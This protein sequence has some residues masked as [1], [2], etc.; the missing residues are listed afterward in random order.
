MRPGFISI[1]S[2]DRYRNRR[3]DVPND[4]ILLEDLTYLL[5]EGGDNIILEQGVGVSY[6]TDTPIQN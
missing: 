3:T 6:E 2:Q 1:R 5:K 4:A